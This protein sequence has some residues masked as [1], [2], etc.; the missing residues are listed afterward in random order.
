MSIKNIVK[1]KKAVK[2]DEIQEELQ[3]DINTGINIKK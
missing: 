3:N 1:T 2:I